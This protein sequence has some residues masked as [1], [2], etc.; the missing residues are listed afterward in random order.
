M[1]GGVFA[2]LRKFDAYP[3][4][5]EDF[6]VKTVS[7]A[8]ISIIAIVVMILLFSSELIY[9][10]SKEVEPELFVD[11]SRNEKMKINIDVV[12]HRMPCS[13]LS[14]DVMDISGEHELD[15]D[16]DLYRE[17]LNLEGERIL[18]E[19]E[20]LE[21]LGDQS[22]GSDAAINAMKTGLDPNRCESCYG[23]ETKEQPC[24]NTC[25]EVRSAYRKKGWGMQNSQ[26]IAQCDREGWTEKIKTE[27]K[28]GC[29][30]FGS[31]QVNKVAGNFHIAPGKS[32]QQNNFHVHDLQSFGKENIGK[33]NMTH[34]INR[35]SFGMEVP[36]SVEPLAGH[37]EA[38]DIQST[39]MFQYFVKIVPTRYRQSSGN[40][41][42][43]NQYSVTM[44]Q[45]QIDFAAGESGLPGVFFMYEITPIL[46]QLSEHNHSFLH[47]LTSLCA[48]IGGIYS[49]AGMIDGFVYHGLRTLQKKQEIGKAG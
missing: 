22:L 30:L 3:K 15:I 41:I 7:G 46:V 17:R 45:K 48:I 10:L 33:F 13:F 20:E 9:F 2:K 35:L 23:A 6:Q 4:T 19:A 14:I 31:L 32:F 24:C 12:F 21:S 39:T 1:S 18:T 29:H 36:G 5:A 8:A 34:T 26:G 44:H 47:F 11:T 38:S 27:S 42:S 25:D 37:H 16:H 43:T 40:E 49:V 28:E